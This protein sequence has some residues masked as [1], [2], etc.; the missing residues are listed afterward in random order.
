MPLRLLVT[1]ILLVASSGLLAML[2]T[3]LGSEV[4]A[5]DGRR[6]LAVWGVVAGVV[7][8]AG[9]WPIRLRAF[10][11]RSLAWVLF[12]G[13]AMRAIVLPTAPFL[14]DD[15][16]R[17]LWDGAV[18]AHGFNPFGLAPAEVFPAYGG[19]AQAALP[20]DLLGTEAEAVL[21]K[22][23]HPH[24]TTVYGPVAQAAFAA[25]HALSPWSMV[26]WRG[27]LLVF[28][29]LTMVAVL[30]LLQALKKPAALAAW[31]WWN[32]VLLRE[33][34]SSGHMD[35]IALPL[36]VAALLLATRGA[37]IVSS[38]ALALAAGVKIWPIV[39]AP[40]V[41]RA[42]GSRMKLSL[43]ATMVF[44][45]L[46]ALL[47]TPALLGMHADSNGFQ[48]YA[49]K[50]YNNDAV[51]AG[52]VWIIRSVLGLA[53]LDAIHAPRIARCVVVGALLLAV[54]IQARRLRGDLSDLVQRSLFVLA[55]MFFLIPAQ[56]PWY[57]LWMLPLLAATPRASLLAYAAFLPLYYVHYELPWVVW[58]EHVPI[59]AWFVGETWASRRRATVAT[60]TVEGG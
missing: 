24:L 50:W 19:A 46:S 3:R 45:T 37:A 18:L 36:V 42:T 49:L 41:G 29:G 53:D 25:A 31:Y 43:I 58:I 40:F 13:L 14:E 21:S 22:I 5:S 30:A 55:T 35:V 60:A 47:W 6:A 56:F 15:F 17:Y 33:V 54:V 1:G 48:A 7:F 52:T 32:P 28:D 39:L 20:A 4:P 34:T 38:V 44:V 9:L 10:G 16:N 8:F 59:L 57:Y 23:T 11:K 12:I 51:F 27:V 2:A 26:A